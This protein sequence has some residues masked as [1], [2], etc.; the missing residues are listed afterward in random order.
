MKLGLKETPLNKPKRNISRLIIILAFLFFY[1]SHN[2]CAEILFSHSQWDL[3]QIVSG[4]QKTLSITV[5]NGNIDPVIL[6]IIS[7]CD[8]LKI[9]SSSLEIPPGKELSF[10]L[11]F[12]AEDPPGEIEK[13][14]IL[15]SNHPE[16]S[17]AL[18]PVTGTLIAQGAP[19]GTEKGAFPRLPDTSPKTKPETRQTAGLPST[20]LPASANAQTGDPATA[21]AAVGGVENADSVTA[22][23]PSTTLEPAAPLASSQEAIRIIEAEYY[24]DP[25]CNACKLFLNKILPSLE[26]EHKV[27]FQLELYDVLKPEHYKIMLSRLEELNTP[28]YSTPVFIV[29]EIVLSGNREIDSQ[30]G[31]V[32]KDGIKYTPL[33]EYEEEEIKF[34]PEGIFLLI[35]I[36]LAG[37]LDGVNPC[38]FST[39]IFLVAAMTLAG[40]RRREVL[41]ISLFF[42]FSV[43]VSYFL[44]GAGMFA[45]LRRAQS[46]PVLSAVIRYILAM[47]LFI[48]ALLSI[49][50]YFKIRRG[51]AGKMILQ[52]PKRMKRAVHSSIRGGLRSGVIALSALAMGFLVSLFELGCTGQIYLPTIAY[53][54]Q[55]G[56]KIKG[57]VSL[58]IYNLGFILPLVAVFI[59]TYQGLGSERLGA[60]FRKHLGSV[61]IATAALFLG[62]GLLTLLLR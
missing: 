42:T 5:H 14:L 2:L 44:V 41:I 51:E 53:M 28:F 61:K 26:Q 31:L 47:A 29:G 45:V 56:S 27:K 21:T 6:N 39:L 55:T 36:F 3:G 59:L 33:K 18:F 8:C 24:H 38:A 35:P 20:T 23:P 60:F 12:I 13:Y 46:F 48:F 50:D 22:G 11:T 30:L 4:E 32:I 49:I 34:D 43:F 16:L 40:K 37:L 17:K 57:Y 9:D 62:L 7:T 19:G 54:V 1:I 25:T 52:L 10:T 58:F 15:R